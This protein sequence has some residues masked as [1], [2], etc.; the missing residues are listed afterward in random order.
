MWVCGA[1]LLTIVVSQ[2]RGCVT[3]ARRWLS[4]F[5]SSSASKCIL[6]FPDNKNTTDG[7]FGAQTI[8]RFIDNF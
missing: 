4:Q 8:L 7:F 6:C 5:E 1:S 2:F 3:V